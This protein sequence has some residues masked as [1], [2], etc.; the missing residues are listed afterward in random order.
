MKI[1]RD[2]SEIRSAL[3]SHRKAEQS[4]GFVPTMGALHE[5]HLSLMRAARSTTDVAVLSIFVNPLQFGPNEDFSRYPRSE[6]R[7]LELAEEEKMDVVF[8][9]R[10]EDMYPTDAA[11]TVT[12]GRLG[13]IVEGAARPG[14]FDG[15]ATVVAKLFNLVDA[16][17]AFFGQKD[18]QQAAVIKRMVKD[19]SFRTR[20]QV[21]PI[22]READG[23][24]LSSRNVYLSPE[25]RRQAPMLNQA[26]RE[27]AGV[28]LDGGSVA[29]A[30]RRVAEV[31]TGAGFEMDYGSVV[32]PETFEPWA[33]G[34][35][36]I[37]IA[38]RLGVTRLIDNLQ[39]IGR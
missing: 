37:V 27:G 25:D 5:G 35:A 14:H 19:L 7:D 26:L 16:D 13:R 11:A 30:E 1:V 33:G 8:I 3:E 34:P 15:V 21:E 10:V 24:A 36:L 4:I 38:A 9:P 28:I 22:V 2:V 29:D 20:I 39:V 23:L 18:A 6:E 12:V 17:V 32:D 31:A